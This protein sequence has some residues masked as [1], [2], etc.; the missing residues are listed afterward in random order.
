MLF[1]QTVRQCPCYLPMLN[2]HRNYF[3][4]LFD[5]PR[6]QTWNTSGVIR[7]ATLNSKSGNSKLFIIQKIIKIF[8]GIIEY[9]FTDCGRYQRS[10]FALLVK[11]LLSQGT[12]NLLSY[13][14]P[15]SRYIICHYLFFFATVVKTRPIV[16]YKLRIILCKE[17]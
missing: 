11:Y 12:I 14:Q 3:P 1:R 15:V 13:S 7:V 17:R 16:E 9:L 5:F 4:A 6:F 10:S 2:S 8:I